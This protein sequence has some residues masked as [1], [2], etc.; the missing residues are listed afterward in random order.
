MGT[1]PAVSPG[2]KETEGLSPC[3]RCSR[4]KQM[5]REIKKSYSYYRAALFYRYFRMPVHRQD[6]FLAGTQRFH[7]FAGLYP[8]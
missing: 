8:V 7:H 5:K 3:S 4:R 1:V 2:T 6:N